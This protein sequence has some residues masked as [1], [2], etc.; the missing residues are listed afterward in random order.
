MIATMDEALGGQTRIHS[1]AT[2][3]SPIYSQPGALA[4]LLANI[5]G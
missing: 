3:H 2:S 1:L 5:A 4:D